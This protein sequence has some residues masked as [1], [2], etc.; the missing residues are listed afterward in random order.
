[1]LKLLN[2]IIRRNNDEIMKTA[3]KNPKYDYNCIK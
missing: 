1:M 2:V 3:M